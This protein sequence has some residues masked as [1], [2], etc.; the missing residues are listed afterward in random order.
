MRDE[1]IKTIKAQKGVLYAKP[2]IVYREN[3]NGRDILSRNSRFEPGY[4]DERGYVPVERWI[5][6]VT[7]AENPKRGDGEGLSVIRLL[8]GGEIKLKEALRHAGREIMGGFAGFWP[9]TKVL[10]IGGEPKKT[11]FGSLEVPPIPP[12]VHSGEIKDG[13]PAGGGKTEAYF[14]PPVDMPPYNKNLS[15]TITRLGIRKNV[16]KEG[17][18]EA[19]KRFGKDDSMY[20]L[21]QEY[22]M[23]PYSGWTIPA[24][25]VHAPGPWPTF[26]I[27]LP[28]DD[29]NLAAW[30][31]GERSDERMY[32]ELVLR[33]IKDEKAF[34]ELLVDWEAST[35][36]DFE[37]KLRR[38]PEVLDEGSWGRRLRIFF[39]M[40]YGEGW[41]IKKKASFPTKEK[42]IAGVVWSGE[43]KLNGTTI[44]Q[45]GNS[46]F[47]ITPNAPVEIESTGRTPL[48]IFTVEPYEERE[49]WK[50]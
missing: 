50:L 6:S 36:P 42:P 32:D 43:G 28:Q 2:T 41:E 25:I 8:G 24:G 40:F 5:M 9:L 48:L 1:I 44:S 23:G 14:F 11:S 19:L 12:H 4:T 15:G 20:E 46:E 16:T 21:L 18:M 38:V 3:Y 33:G 39:D 7:E 47:L 17:F 27:Q 22:P 34:V 45:S 26:E 29:F 30:R 10:D 13:K 31:L 37:K 49:K 35:A